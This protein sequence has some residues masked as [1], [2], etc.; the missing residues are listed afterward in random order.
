M[1]EY[2]QDLIHIVSV[3]INVFHRYFLTHLTP[4]DLFYLVT[5]F[6]DKTASV[7]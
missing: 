2:G 5:A 4:L 7:P 3:S 6:E 1:S